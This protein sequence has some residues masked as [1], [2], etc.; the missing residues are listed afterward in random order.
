MAV[1]ANAANWYISGAFQGWSHCQAAYQLKET[2]TGVF[3]LELPAYNG[4]KSISGGFVICQG[5]LNTPDWNNK[6]GTNGQKVVADTPYKYVKG[7]GDFTMDGTV[8]DAV[9]TLDTNAGTL[10]IAGKAKEN[11]YTTVY[12]VGDLG[13][14]SGWNDSRTDF[15]MTLKS[16]TNDTWEAHYSFT[17]ASNYFKMRAG[18]N[19]YSTGGNDIEV[20][21]GT[22]YT[23]TTDGGNSFVLPAGEYDF[24]F[25][26]PYNADN[27]TLTVTGE[28]SGGG[29]SQ[30][31][32]YSSWYVN[33][34]GPFNN[35]ADNGVQPVDGISTTTG[36]GIGLQGFKIKVWPGGGSDVYYVSDGSAI[37]TDTWVQLYQDAY[38]ADPIQIEGATADA[39]YTVKFNCATNEVFVTLTSGGG[40]GQVTPTPE[41]LYIIGD[42]YD[43]DPSKGAEMTDEGGIYTYELEIEDTSYFAFVTKLGENNEDW[44]I[45]SYRYGSKA[46]NNG[47]EESAHYLYTLEDLTVGEEVESLMAYPSE[48]SWG[49]P[50][51]K[52]LL[53]AMIEEEDMTLVIEPLQLGNGEEPEPEPTPE[54]VSATYNFAVIAAENYEESDWASTS[55]GTYIDIT[56]VDFKEAGFNLTV[57]K[58]TTEARLFKTTAGVIDLRFYKDG[59]VMTITAPTGYK[60]DKVDLFAV[61]TNSSTHLNDITVADTWTADANTAYPSSDYKLGRTFTPANPEA[62]YSEIALAAGNTTRVALVNVSASLISTG[63]DGVDAELDADAPVVY[64]NLQGAKVNNPENGIFIRVQGNKVTKVIK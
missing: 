34:L 1:S 47:P 55:G 51:G 31:G 25:V 52:Y 63:I 7:G 5:T 8:D 56:G 12:L 36:L 39:V 45:N 43:W 32:D 49:L 41:S 4:S 30:P 9:I 29:G 44:S 58:G 62:E 6:I 50:A 42:M 28:S 10:L 53:T 24:T 17:N 18:N 48:T 13:S 54:T 35:W 57:T 2:T 11:E 61:S 16:G 64:Y 27:G 60:I 40:G 46:Q 15:P 38:N 33:V 26:L 37:A 23:A 3:T 19:Q 22:S 21:L 14:S 20:T 59:G